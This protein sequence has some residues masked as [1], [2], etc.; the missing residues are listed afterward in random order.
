MNFTSKLPGDIK[1]HKEAEEQATWT[2]DQDLVEKKSLAC[3][4]PYSE[5]L[6]HRTSIEWLVATDQVNSLVSFRLHFYR[7]HTPFCSP[8]KLFNTQN[9]GN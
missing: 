8:Y 3:I 6:F 4:I 7:L 2:L 1:K 5:Q 9:F